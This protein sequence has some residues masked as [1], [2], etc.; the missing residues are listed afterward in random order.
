MIT[1]ELIEYV[2]TCREQNISDEQITTTLKEQGW[3][4][5]DIN[6]GLAQVPQFTE[7]IQPAES[8]KTQKPKKKFLI[9]LV[10]GILIIGGGIFAW[11]FFSPSGQ[12]VFQNKEYGF[13]L[14]YP[15]NWT[16]KEEKTET[17]Y[18]L[19][20]VHP[21]DQTKADTWGDVAVEFFIGSD[22][23]ERFSKML[24][25]LKLSLTSGFVE[26]IETSSIAGFKGEE[27]LM[28]SEN[29]RG[30]EIT[31][32]FPSKGCRVLGWSADSG[33]GKYENKV[34]EIL[35]TFKFLD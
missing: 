16:I 8:I 10:I 29:A 2:K 20:V 33:G 31:Y 21:S 7:P 34:K 28:D 18:R 1:K 9:P 24:D 17:K 12:V 15:K 27:V 6:V 5:E 19:D 13:E 4:D 35:S 23:N 32:L 30:V 14:Q 22:N 11:Q 26:D 3:A 25:T